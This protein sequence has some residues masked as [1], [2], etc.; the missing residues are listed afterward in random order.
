MDL[1]SPAASLDIAVDVAVVMRNMEKEDKENGLA[2]ASSGREEGKNRHHPQNHV[3]PEANP[4][5]VLVHTV[6]AV[7]VGFGFVAV[8]VV[9]AAVVV[10]GEDIDVHLLHWSRNRLLH[11]NH[12]ST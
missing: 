9:A 3:D 10:G 5:V 1:G 6:V 12:L 8:V 11:W 2:V 4:G 7:V